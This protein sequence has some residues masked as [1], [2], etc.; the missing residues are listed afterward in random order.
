MPLPYFPVV[1]SSIAE[2]MLI[3]WIVQQSSNGVLE[4]TVTFFQTFRAK[5]D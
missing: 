3:D 4:M 1:E 2:L 5:I